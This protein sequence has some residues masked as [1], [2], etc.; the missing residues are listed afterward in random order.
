M[1]AEE[2]IGMKFGNYTITE[3]DGYRGK[4]LYMRCRC[5]CGSEKSLGIGSLRNGTI[6]SCGCKKIVKMIGKRFGKLEVLEFLGSVNKK[7]KFLCKCDC[8]RE[9]I[10]A[11]GDLRGGLQISCGC[12]KKERIAKFGF[13]SKKHGMSKTKT[14]YSW[15][16][17]HDRCYKKYSPSYRWYGAKGV[18]VCKS[19]HKFEEFYKD[20]G[21]RPLGM[22]LDRID[23]KKN[24]EPSNCKWSTPLE[25]TKNRGVKK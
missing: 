4:N 2:M 24:Y 18:S 17:M 20:M 9:I 14:Y 16:A 10:V 3:K 6:T 21:D 11:G 8:S 5:D 15:F 1:R 22:T 13:A 25:Q 19:W 23:P 12:S 7:R